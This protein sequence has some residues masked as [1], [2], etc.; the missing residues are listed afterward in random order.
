MSDFTALGAMVALG[1]ANAFLFVFMDRWVNGRGDTIATGVVRGVRISARHRRYVLQ[2]RLIL[3]AG[4]LIVVECV[5]AIGWLL[6]AGNAG[7]SDLKFLAYVLAFINAVGAIGWVA[8]L[9]SHYRHLATVM[10]EAEAD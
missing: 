5:L 7:A 2:V 10:R 8:T 4:T 6:V 9:P 3:N 1:I